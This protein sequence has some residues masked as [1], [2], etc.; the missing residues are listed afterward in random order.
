MKFLELTRTNDTKVLININNVILMK[1]E[2]GQNQTLLQFD[3]IAVTVKESIQEIMEKALP[4][5]FIITEE[6]KM[7]RLR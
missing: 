5:P 7:E 1:S 4:A 6:G 3:Q 2:A